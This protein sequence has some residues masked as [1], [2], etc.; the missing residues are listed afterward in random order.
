MRFAYDERVRG[1]EYRRIL[2][3][4]VDAGRGGDGYLAFPANH[5]LTQEPILW[6]PGTVALL[7]SISFSTA[8]PELDSA[9]HDTR[10]TNLCRQLGLCQLAKNPVSLIDPVVDLVLGVNA[11][12]EKIPH[13]E[14]KGVPKLRGEQ[15]TQCCDEDSPPTGS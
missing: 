12:V 11:T 15:Y 7:P 14:V 4:A 13:L 9:A 3:R 6:S 10:M 8:Y 5:Q 2:T 1:F